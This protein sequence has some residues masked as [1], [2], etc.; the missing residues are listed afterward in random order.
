MDSLITQYRAL[1]FLAHRAHNM[2]KGPTFFEDHEFLGEL[3]PAYEAAYDSLVERVIGLGSEKL[4]IT[5]INRVAADMSAVAPDETKAE[6]F[7]RIILKGE[8][9]LCGLIDKAMAKASNGTQDLLQGLC[10]ASE[11][12]QYQLKQRLG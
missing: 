10:N 3:Y 2:V 6:T 11:A 5:K 1:Q 8:K 12:R 9:D 7:F 4:S